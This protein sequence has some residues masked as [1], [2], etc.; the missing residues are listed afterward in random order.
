MVYNSKAK[1]LLINPELDHKTLNPVAD[2]RRKILN[3]ISKLN[4]WDNQK[5]YFDRTEPRTGQWFLDSVEFKGW[6]EGE[7]RVLWCPGDRKIL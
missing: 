4:Y 3:W 2:E 5:D 1:E 7:T 6:M